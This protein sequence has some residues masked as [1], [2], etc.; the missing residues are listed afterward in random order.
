VLKR[1]RVLDLWSGRITDEGARLLAASPDIRHLQRLR[2]EQNILTARGV[3]ALRE[4][5]VK[6]EAGGQMEPGF[7]EDNEHLFEGDAE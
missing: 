3:R 4:T 2:I 7:V 1:L 6:L 5:G